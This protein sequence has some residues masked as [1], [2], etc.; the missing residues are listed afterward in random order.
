[1][2]RPEGVSGFFDPNGGAGH[3]STRRCWTFSSRVWGS[4]LLDPTDCGASRGAG[5]TRSSVRS[6]PRPA[7]SERSTRKCGNEP[8]LSRH[9]GVQPPAERR[10]A[11]HDLLERTIWVG[12]PATRSWADVSR[13]ATLSIAMT[14][15][16]SAK[17]RSVFT[18]SAARRSS[19]RQRAAPHGQLHAP[20]IL[21]HPTVTL[22]CGLPNAPTRHKGQASPTHVRRAVASGGSG[23]RTDSIV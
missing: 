1:M 22:L 4:E 15:A 2:T 5:R 8:L 18:A 11:N 6:R 23:T 16:R 21:R 20:D 3:P 17:S 19:G 7:I 14:S 12:V 9:L 13:F 10:R